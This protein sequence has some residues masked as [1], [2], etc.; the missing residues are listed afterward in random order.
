MYES[1]WAV[2]T[3]Y[4]RPGDLN[5]RDVFSLGSGGSKSK[6]KVP[7][8]LASGQASLPGSETAAMS[9]CPHV[10]SSLGTHEGSVPFLIRTPA[11][12]DEGPTPGL[13]LTLCFFK[14]EELL[15]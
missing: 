9:L 12:S 5:N 2:L 15:G 10:A 6:M 13:R 14:N 7:S 4:H 11:P 1:A 8:G 3:K